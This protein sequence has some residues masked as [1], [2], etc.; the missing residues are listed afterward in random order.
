MDRNLAYLKHGLAPWPGLEP[1]IEKEVNG[2]SIRVLVRSLGLGTRTLDMAILEHGAV[3]RTDEQS[4]TF[5]V[6]ATRLPG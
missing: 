6:Q 2:R 4:P 5:P 1:S 3:D